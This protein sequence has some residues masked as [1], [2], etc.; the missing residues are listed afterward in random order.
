MS[1]VRT[2]MAGQVPQTAE[3]YVEAPVKQ[4]L[5]RYVRTRNV[6]YIEDEEVVVC[7]VELRLRVHTH[8]LAK[9]HSRRVV[10]RKHHLRTGRVRQPRRD[11]VHVLRDAA[12]VVCG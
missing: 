3:K 8:G 11:A 10:D 2:Q 1:I 12:V 4:M 9:R 5:R 6:R 7:R